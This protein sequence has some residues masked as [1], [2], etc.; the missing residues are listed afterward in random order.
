MSKSWS[1]FFVC[2]HRKA[3]LEVR[4]D[5]PSIRD[6]LAAKESRMADWPLAAAG[7]VNLWLEVIWRS[8]GH[9]CGARPDR[10]LCPWDP[11]ALLLVPVR[12][13]TLRSI[14]RIQAAQHTC[15]ADFSLRTSVGKQET[16][17]KAVGQSGQRLEIW[18]RGLLLADWCR[19][20]CSLTATK[21]NLAYISTERISVAS[22]IFFQKNLWLL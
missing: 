7:K 15:I 21:I 20:S 22:D 2:W 17:N 11:P 14:R 10:C 4:G 16:S 6:D 13:P 8:Q 18:P 12:T 19:W 1:D 5:M 9:I 3:W